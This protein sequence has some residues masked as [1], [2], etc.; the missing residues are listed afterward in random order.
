[1]HAYAVTGYAA[2]GQVEVCVGAV[3]T[4]LLVKEYDLSRAYPRNAFDGNVVC[5]FET[6]ELIFDY[7]FDLLSISGEQSFAL[8]S[9]SDDGVFGRHSSSDT[10]GFDK[11]PI[12][13]AQD[14]WYSYCFVQVQGVMMCFSFD[15]LQGFDPLLFIWLHKVLIRFCF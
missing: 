2:A 8:L 7:A 14:V 13:G 9:V 10:G 3:D 11:L 12:P 4:S 5:Q 1:V 15:V 6:Q